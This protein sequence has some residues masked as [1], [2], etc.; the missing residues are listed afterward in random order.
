MFGSWYPWEG[1]RAGIGGGAVMIKLRLG[2]TCFGLIEP[3]PEG[4]LEVPALDIFISPA[5]TTAF[6]ARNSRR[7]PTTTASLCWKQ[8]VDD[9]EVVS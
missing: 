9:H 7:Q 8:T 3:D 1:V 6:A 4:S 5:N 2:A